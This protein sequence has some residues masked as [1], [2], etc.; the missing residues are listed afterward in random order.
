LAEKTG[1]AALL[2][3]T[4]EVVLATGARDVVLTAGTERVVLAA[5]TRS[6]LSCLSCARAIGIMRATS[7]DALLGRVRKTFTWASVM[8][9]VARHETILTISGAVDCDRSWFTP[10]GHRRRGAGVGSGGGV[11][12]VGGRHCDVCACVFAR[13]MK[14]LVGWCDAQRRKSETEWKRSRVEEFGA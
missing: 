12:S 6:G 7:E 14:S 5:A 8:G 2:A 9:L 3:G 4:R 1:E 11:V 10:F 13:E